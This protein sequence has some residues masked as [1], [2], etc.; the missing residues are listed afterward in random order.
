MG[1]DGVI[2]YWAHANLQRGAAA[3]ALAGVA[4]LSGVSFGGANR[5]MPTPQPA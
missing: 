5:H 2:L 1:I 3:A 4:H